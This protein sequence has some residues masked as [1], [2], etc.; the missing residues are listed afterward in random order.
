MRPHRLYRIAWVFVCSWALLAHR[1]NGE[2][3]RLAV[4]YDEPA[5]SPWSILTERGT[6]FQWSYGTSFGG[7]P[8]REAPLVTDRPDF[9][10]SPVT[11]GRGVTQLELGYTYTFD[12]DG[13]RQ[14]IGHT[15]P[16]LLMR[17]GVVAQ[18]L[19]LRVGWTWEELRVTGEPT[20][21]GAG[22]LLLGAKIALTPQEGPL[23]EMAIIPQMFVPV[24]SHG[25]SAQRVLPGLNWTYAWEVTE[26]CSLGG[27]TQVNLLLDDQTNEPFWEISQSLT[28]GLA[29]TE[30]I[31]LYGEWFALFPNG[32]DTVLPQY[33]A[34]T[35]L[36]LLVTHDL[37]WDVRIGLGLND[38]ADDYF[39]GTGL[40]IRY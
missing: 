11:V 6:L 37:Q 35:G 14:H 1:A 39:A 40:A 23:P 27:Q 28:V 16:E 17:V 24:G 3:P 30:R 20:L 29:L 21:A 5:G 31:G 32:A 2:D 33:L 19:E 7:G 8:D 22:D 13:T 10:E 15:A 26:R 9:T 36:T 18:W 38:A 34:N 12:H 4:P 25:L